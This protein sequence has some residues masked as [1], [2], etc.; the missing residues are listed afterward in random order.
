LRNHTQFHLSVTSRSSAAAV[1][2]VF[3]AWVVA[4]RAR[5]EISALAPELAGLARRKLRRG[6]KQ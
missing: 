1:G 5:P 4:L 2:I 3:A 6:W